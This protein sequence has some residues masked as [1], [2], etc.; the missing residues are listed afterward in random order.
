MGK[1]RNS[2]ILIKT[3]TNFYGSPQRN[4]SPPPVKNNWS[5]VY[6][7]QATPFKIRVETKPYF[8]KA[9]RGVFK[10]DTN[11]LKIIMVTL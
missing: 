2:K 10:T 6:A 3:Q 5:R 8:G 1:C 4:T 11:L 9:N 7:M